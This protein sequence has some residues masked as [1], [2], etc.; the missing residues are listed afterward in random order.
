MSG[1]KDGDRATASRRRLVAAGGIGV[2]AG[3]G[4]LAAAVAAAEAQPVPAASEFAWGNALQRIKTAGKVVFA[5]SGSPTPP[6]YY[7]DPDSNKPIGYDVEIANLIARDL[8]V[9]P[10]FEEAGVAARISGL[11]SGKYD[12]ALG[13]TVNSPARAQ[14]VG[15][16]RGYVPYRQV[17][18]VGAAAKFQSADE[19]DNPKYTI[20]VAAGST[21]EDTAKLVFTR[22]NIK[23]LRLN[24]AVLAVAGGAASASLLELYLAAPFAKA[25]PSVKVLGE[26]D[27]PIVVATEYGC[28]A[29]RAAE[30][31]LR[32]WLENW[33]YWYE[34]HGVLN[35]MYA[36][37]MA[38]A[39]RAR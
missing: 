8:G 19:L 5:Q 18:L 36:R 10:V 12:I 24:D 21:A 26:P 27:R 3:V 17:L 34:S 37:I 22:A 23:P 20:T 1:S 31:D 38:A 6:L 15:F 25:Q 16:T 29:C 9:E 7:R 2:L 35:A 13:G 33:V 39:Q 32:Q 4:S 14:L 30:M 11:Q 28:L